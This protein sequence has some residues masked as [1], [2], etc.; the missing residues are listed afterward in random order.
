MTISYISYAISKNDP[1]AVT[2]NETY[3]YQKVTKRFMA[4][5][6]EISE[7]ETAYDVV[8]LNPAVVKREREARDFLEYAKDFE[9][10]G[11]TEKALTYYIRAVKLQ[12]DL[13]L[14]AYKTVALRYLQETKSQIDKQNNRKDLGR[15]IQIRKDAQRSFRKAESIR[16]TH[17]M[18]SKQDYRHSIQIAYALFSAL[19]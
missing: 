6:S 14:E 16:E 13:V 10:V 11:A 7:L 9:I 4:Q 19:A 12:N 15:F 3:R 2:P 8:L 18:R 17:P 1:G 5:L